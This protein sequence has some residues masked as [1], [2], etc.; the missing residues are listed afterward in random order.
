MAPIFWFMRLSIFVHTLR[1]SAAAA[2][3]LWRLVDPLIRINITR[4]FPDV[5]ILYDPWF[6]WSVANPQG[7]CADSGPVPRF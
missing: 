6:S 4:D 2:L 3:L 5:S 1:S 7:F